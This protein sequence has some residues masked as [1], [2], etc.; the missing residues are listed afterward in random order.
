MEHVPA[1]VWCSRHAPERLFE[2]LRVVLL[3][4]AFLCPTTALG[5]HGGGHGGGGHGGSH[6]R[7]AAHAAGGRRGNGLAWHHS[8]LASQR[9]FSRCLFPWRH[10][11]GF[12]GFPAFFGFTAF[13]LDYPDWYY[14][15]LD[16]CSPYYD[17]DCNCHR[18]P[19]GCDERSLLE[20]PPP[21]PDSDQEA[22][23]VAP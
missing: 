14:Q 3:C 9:A 11:H 13:G 21:P 22:P 6:G 10:H 17:P 8:S 2:A 7:G 15:P 18:E 20:P 1:K 23:G 5:S 19:M 12:F 16:L 4:A